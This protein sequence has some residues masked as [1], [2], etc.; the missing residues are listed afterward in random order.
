[1][2]VA[3]VQVSAEANTTGTTVNPSLT[4]VTAGNTLIAIACGRLLTVATGTIT[5]SGFTADN[6]TDVGSGNLYAVAAALR[7][8]N[9]AAGS[10]S[11][12]LTLSDSNG[13][14]MAAIMLE[15][16][17]LDNTSPLDVNFTAAQINVPTTGGV[18]TLT[19]TG[20]D[21]ATGE[22]AI[23]VIA[24]P[25]GNSTTTLTS[26]SGWTKDVEETN[27]SSY[28]GL[29]VAHQVQSGTS[30]TGNWGYN[31]PS[32]SYAGYFRGFLLSYKA[33]SGGGTSASATQTDGADTQAATG[34]PLI[35]SSAAQTDGAD[36]QA[37]TGTPLITSSA[38]Q[39]DG[40]DTQVASAS[41]GT[42]VS[43]SAAQT[44]GADT[45]AAK[46]TPLIT[47][48]AAQT[49]GTD[50]QAAT[51]TPLITS[52]AAQT[53]G[54]DTQAAT[55]T[56]LITSSAAQTDG[57]D[58]QAA[59]GTPLI[60]SSAAQTDGA[61]IQSAHAA[62][63]TGVAASAAQTDSADTQAATGTPLITSSAAQADPTDIQVAT[64]YVAFID[65]NLADL[66]AC[67]QAAVSQYYT[68]SKPTPLN[69]QV[70]ITSGSWTVPA[71]TKTVYVSATA[72]G[73]SPFGGAGQ[74]ALKQQLKAAVGDTVSVTI[75]QTVAVS[76][77][78][79][80]QLFLNPGGAYGKFQAQ[81]WGQSSYIQGFGNGADTGSGDPALAV[82][83]WS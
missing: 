61:D 14:G 30:V 65:A 4:G 17:G 71:N 34:T 2:T 73:G 47:S 44:D 48:S 41:I 67:Q 82:I 75:G 13:G 20:T 50:T 36:T 16:S 12:T 69:F 46:A 81:S 68:G 77:N 10:H 38:A 72:A 18:G 58:T 35:T 26:P 40:A 62:P 32:G 78:G 54:A 11:P 64:V 42:A 70:F 23:S 27:I 80:Q 49:D 21:A 60:T 59:T 57:T 29:G 6:T 8:S 1:M 66:F 76:V 25:Y 45:Q 33:A 74:Q 19:L 39:T 55:A 3:V 83:L 22:L 9:V 52:S 79:A 37:A 24:F 63:I 53:D 51:G 7:Q 43:A 15:V 28:G 5:S 31:Y 56:P